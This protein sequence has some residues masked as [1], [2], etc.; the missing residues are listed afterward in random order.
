MQTIEEKTSEFIPSSHILVK[1]NHKTFNTTEI[2]MCGNTCVFYIERC[3]EGEIQAGLDPEG[4]YWATWTKNIELNSTTYKEGHPT[5]DSALAALDY[6]M[7]CLY[8][9]DSPWC[10]DATG[11]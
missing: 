2:V 3:T 11:F 4:F 10:S 1:P 9:L 6:E 7:A 5:L 8:G